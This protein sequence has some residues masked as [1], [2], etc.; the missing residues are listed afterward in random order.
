[1]DTPVLIAQ[2]LDPAYRVLN[3]RPKCTRWIR[4]PPMHRISL[5][6]TADHGWKNPIQRTDLG[7]DSA[8]RGGRKKRGL[9]TVGC[10]KQLPPIHR[11][12][13]AMGPVYLYPIQG[14]SRSFNHSLDPGGQVRSVP[15]RSLVDYALKT[16]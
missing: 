13:S 2:L 3:D 10:H 16:G 4:L 8:D 7:V 5:T 1:M 14:P 6:G 11:P 12:D 15:A 9:R